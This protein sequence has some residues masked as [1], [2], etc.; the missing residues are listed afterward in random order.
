[1]KFHK[2][3]VSEH[4]AAFT[5]SQVLVSCA[6][7]C[8]NLGPCLCSPIPTHQIQ[9]D[10]SEQGRTTADAHKVQNAVHT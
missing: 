9:Y 1:M 4:E 5:M 7:N 3:P 6:C 10:Q 2:R 8:D